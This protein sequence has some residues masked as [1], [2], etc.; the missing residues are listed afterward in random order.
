MRGAGTEDVDSVSVSA[1]DGGAR[2]RTTGAKEEI[3][4]RMTEKKSEIT[5]SSSLPPELLSHAHG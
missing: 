1:I 5:E 2:G 4:G 3:I